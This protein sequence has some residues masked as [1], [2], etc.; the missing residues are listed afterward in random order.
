MSYTLF[1]D[2]TKDESN[3]ALCHKNRLLEYNTEDNDHVFSV[4]DVYVGEVRKI[5]SGLNSCF[6]N[7][8]GQG[9]DGFLHYHDLGPKV[10]S[11]NSIINKSILGKNIDISKIKTKED[12]DK[13]GVISEILKPKDKILV[14]IVKE[15]ILTK[16]PRL[17]GEISL[18]GRYLVLLPFSNSI[19]ISQKIQNFKE[20]K[21]LKN[22][23]HKIKKNNFGIIARTMS[24]SKTLKDLKNDL[25]DLIDNWNSLVRNLKSVSNPKKLYGNS[26][27]LNM[28]LRD[29]LNDDFSS[30]YVN[31]KE[32][33]EQ[34][35]SY[36]S[37]IKFKNQN[38]LKL[39]N[40]KIPMFD[41]YGLNKQIKSAFGKIVPIQKGVY[42]VIEHTEAMHVIDVNS[43]NKLNSSLDQ[44]ENAIAVNLIAAKEIV[45][46]LRLRDMGGIII[47]D[48]IDMKKFANKNKLFNE[49]R[50][51]MRGDRAKNHIL[52][53]TRY[54]LL[55]ITRE[56]VRQQVV[57]KKNN[58]CEDCFKESNLLIS[59]IENKL[60]F[61]SRDKKIKK[62]TLNVNPILYGFLTKGFFSYKL[63]WMM[64]YKILIKLQKED[65]NLYDFS[66][67]S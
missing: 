9:K 58:F 17:S 16:G 32:T 64:K 53:L 59:D 60:S 65:V 10:N 44:E 3:I 63:K 62:I 13:K 39:Y 26:G 43:G 33:F 7:L 22:I 34:V 25:E 48:F 20:K 19:T 46:Q 49:I 28:I 42:L 38:I 6:V 66:Y 41:F 45:R 40:S 54:G 37:K 29:T 15:P 8:G 5:V 55:Q 1:I 2:E 52:P 18:A 14:Q 12:I 35:K 36:L 67:D 27:R 21:R 11:F 61:F 4:G 30:I 50:K 24:Q 47:V 56:R 31:K 57:I 23:L 51:M